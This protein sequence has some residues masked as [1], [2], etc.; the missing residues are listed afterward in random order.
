M[1]IQQAQFNSDLRTSLED[2]GGTRFLAGFLDPI[3]MIP[4]PFA[5]GKGFIAGA[6]RA[7]AGGAPIIA[8]SELARH[9]FDP[10]STTEETAINILAGTMFMG[11]IGGA[12]GRYTRSPDAI[13][14]GKSMQNLLNR[15][16]PLDAPISA[17]THAGVPVS[18]G[19]IRGI[20]NRTID[21]IQSVAR[22]GE[23]RTPDVELKV[24]GKP[25]TG[26]PHVVAEGPEGYPLHYLPEEGQPGGAIAARKTLEIQ[27]DDLVELKLRVKNDAII[28][29]VAQFTD[30]DRT[31][32]IKVM[33]ANIR[34][35][36][37][38][39]SRGDKFFD[40]PEVK[41]QEVAEAKLLK[42]D[43]TP[44]T[45]VKPVSVKNKELD[46]ISGVPKQ[47][48]AQLREFTEINTRLKRSMSE[49]R[50]R[51]AALEA[52]AKN[53]PHKA[54]RTRRL[55]ETKPLKEELQYQKDQQARVDAT[56]GNIRRAISDLNAKEFLQD[57]DLMPAAMNTVLGKLKQFP[58]WFL[59]KNDFR[60]LG[61]AVDPK[62]ADE[63]QLFSFQVAGTPGLSN[64]GNALGLTSGPSIE[65]MAHTWFGP[66][67][68]AM[69]EKQRL[70]GA[71]IGLGEDATM[72]NSF[73]V[74][75]KQ[76]VR[77]SF[78]KFRTG[79]KPTTTEDGKL[80][81]EE[82]NH[83]ISRT[84]M[85]GETHVEPSIN[86]AAAEYQKVF[87]AMGDE[88]R[89]LG[90]FWTQ[91]NA[92][93]LLLKTQGQ[94]DDYKAKVK[95]NPRMK[96]AMQDAIDELEMEKLRIEDEI[97]AYKDADS[98]TLDSPDYFHRMWRADKVRENK[99]QLIDL[100]VNWFRDNPIVRRGDKT[101]KLSVDEVQ[102]RAR[103][104]EAYSSILRE[105]DLGD[106][107]FQLN[108]IDKLEWL[109]ERLAR[110]VEMND[111][112]SVARIPIIERKIEK[113]RLGENTVGGAGPLIQRKM[114]I[115]NSMLVEGGFIET[116]IDA[117]VAHYV[118]RMGSAIETA[119]KFGDIRGD[120]KINDLFKRMIGAAMRAPGA[121]QKKKLIIRAKEY[122]E[123]MRDLL[124]ITQGIYQIPDDPAAITGRV[125]RTLRNF[126]VLTAMGR[127]TLMAL[128]DTGNIIISQGF[129]NTFGNLIDRWSA[130]TLKGGVKM[131][132]DEV[133][134]AGSVV[135]VALGMRYHQFTEIGATW[136]AA[137]KLERAVAG[138]AQKFFLYNLLAPWTDMAKKLSGGMI[139]S[140]MIENSLLWRAGKLSDEEA[141]IMSRLGINKE[142]ATQIANMWEAAGSLKHKDMFIANTEQWTNDLLRR[143][144]RA[145]L[146][147]EVMRAVITPGAPDKPKALLKSEWWKVFGQYKGFSISAT[148][149]IL[150]A[151][152]Q[153]KG[154]QKYAG[155]ASM[156]GIAMMVD[157]FKRPD[158]I[159]LSTY[160]Q[161][162]RAVELSGVTGVLLDLNDTI[163]RASAGAVGIRPALGMDI[164]ERSP[165]WANRTGALAGAVPNQW[166]QMMWALTSEEAET[167]DQARVT[168]YMIPYNNLFY[169]KTVFDRMQRG[170]VNEIEEE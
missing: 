44:R 97:K 122:R 154:A 72:F 50:E 31:E 52:K 65:N 93:R 99:D 84:M 125:L 48:R 26:E 121:K 21:G 167:S 123:A 96:V 151:G 56:V 64:R 32:V 117:V 74:D 142:G 126:N 33:E 120:A 88:G 69:K 162:L 136:T 10:T 139:Q 27:R 9:K 129:T 47:I 92:E 23:K 38:D 141:K 66:F 140:K 146:N 57:W 12:A 134:L 15:I 119:R 152:L 80:T 137:N 145:A 164:R 157:Q 118:A 111:E 138:S 160:E 16:V 60:G 108:S 149:R 94:L 20:I 91:K 159:R 51:I 81:L 62:L 58:F 54:V 76:R 109:N 101:M 11:L 166:L 102:L 4:V 13:S 8:A 29:E 18:F 107:E 110:M 41:A 147:N 59:I 133:T 168:R 61:D 116:D 83:E 161:V 90:I 144:F 34:K 150:G 39:V 45:D 49:L 114:D 3:N 165:N 14:A 24:K 82:F 78:K 25:D 113:I 5:L 22:H 115:P 67:I 43:G 135:E 40:R 1:I 155:F 55:N 63:L 86:K 170:V 128:A 17:T 46:I 104:E 37:D 7:I 127:A 158:Y 35:L 53:T 19:S 30:L 87:K 124:D 79:E 77:G 6:K 89:Q 103:A 42:E 36:E 169:W 105:A 131:M 130:S 163:E 112:V 98:A 85:T 153:Q 70:Y 68:A 95:E 106:A 2:Y 71:Y 28:D 73:V 132:D 143:E 75:T 100:L 148:H 156:I